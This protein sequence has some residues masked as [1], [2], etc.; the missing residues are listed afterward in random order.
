MERY[1]LILKNERHNRIRT[2]VKYMYMLIKETKFS[3]NE[4]YKLR[5]TNE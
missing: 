3:M 1:I 5:M 4:I 2:N